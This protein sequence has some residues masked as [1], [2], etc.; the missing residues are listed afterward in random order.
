MGGKEEGVVELV[1]RG[2]IL[3][4]NYSLLRFPILSVRRLDQRSIFNP[5]VKTNKIIIITKRRE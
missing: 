4:G 5:E 3:G 2:I 1:R